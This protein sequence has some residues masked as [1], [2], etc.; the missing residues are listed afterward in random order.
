MTLLNFPETLKGLPV[1]SRD[2]I[3][4]SLIVAF[5]LIIKSIPASILELGNDE[6]YYWTYALFPDWSHFDHPPMVGLLIQLFSLNLALKGELFI[7]MGPLILSSA[8]IIILFSLVRRLHSRPAAYL[9]VMLYISSIY[10]NIIG[11]LFILPDAP[12]IFFTLLAL[13]YL[14][15]SVTVKDPSRKDHFNFVMF[16]LFTGLAF[17]SKYHSLFLWF[18]AGL[19]IVLRNRIWLKRPALYLGILVSLIMALP[20]IYWNIRNNFISFAYHGGRIGLLHSPL[21]FG[22]FLQFNLGQFFYQN[23]V[24]CGVYLVALYRIIRDRNHKLREINLVL[25]Y[26]GLPL[27]LTFMF[28]SFF[29]DVLPHWS[30]PAFICM[31]IISSI[32]L[33][34]I[35]VKRKKVVVR[36]LT[37]ASA[38]LAVILIVGTVQI[39]TGLIG[40]DKDSGAL[41]P[42]Q[43]DFTLDMF[44]WKQA[45]EKFTGFL[46]RQKI[47]E[48]EYPNLAMVT[49][50][51]FPAAHLDYYIA[52]PLKIRLLALGDIKRIH[53]YYWI[54]KTRKLARTDRVLYITDSRNYHGPEEFAGCFTGIIPLDT[55]IIERRKKEVKYIYIY[56]LVGFKCDSVLYSLHP[57]F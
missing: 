52:N 26:L 1:R 35:F 23:P 56:D 17:L 24:L 10:F 39:K 46:V 49:E 20:V 13:T 11:G 5:N 32:Y 53:K 12:Q 48:T 29:R 6:V 9:A 30:G 34:D 21:N 18:G 42:G 15:P 57:S 43:D 38:L 51:W 7:R 54:N 28:L 47:P 27:I 45:K 3:F 4:L 8:G 40:P 16:G 41:Y 55:L 44:G 50:N 36:W 2:M 37:A 33:A 14:L 22:S 31:I 25:V 19:Y